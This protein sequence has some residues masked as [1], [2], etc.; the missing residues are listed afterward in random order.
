M[1]L[2]FQVSPLVTPLVTPA[3]SPLNSPTHHFVSPPKTPDL[4]T[5]SEQ[6]A[7]IKLYEQNLI[8]PDLKYATPGKID[9][10]LLYIIV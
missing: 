7:A 10:V 5:T 8:M 4:S 9:I 2:Q 3:G 6:D 1:Y